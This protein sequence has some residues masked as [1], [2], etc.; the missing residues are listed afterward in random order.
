MLAEFIHFVKSHKLFDRSEPLLV[1]VSGGKDSVCLA[2]LFSLSEYNFTIAHCNFKLRGNESDED[3]LFVKQLAKDLG[4]NY[5]EKV[6]D[7]AQYAEEKKLSIQEAAR[8]LRYNWFREIKEKHGFSKI[9]TAHHQ[10]DSVET[11]FIN[12]FRS[13]GIS[14]LTGIPI[15]SNDIVRPLLF[16]SRSDI[17]RHIQTFNLN[18]RE[19][20]S[21]ITNDYL[22]N[23]IR[24]ELIP[25]IQRL[26]N[27]SYNGLLKS[28]EFLKSDNVLFQYL[29]NKEAK[30]F[31]KNK[32]DKLI[33]DLILL[34]QHP[35]A[36]NILFQLLKPYGFHKN[37]V[38]KILKSEESGKIFYSHNFRAAL[39]RNELIISKINEDD[40][41]T[42][43]LITEHESEIGFPLKLNLEKIAVN[44][45]EFNFEKNISYI[46]ADK[47]IWP[48]ELRK[49]QNGDSFVPLGMK[50]RKKVSDFLIDEKVSM[51]E[52]ENTWVL[53]SNNEIVWLVGH[54][55]SDK[56]KITDSTQN[57]LKLEIIS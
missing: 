45:V 37:E 57:V 3:A 41:V 44:Q 8:N 48:L 39:N 6:F 17:D 21:N 15:I 55:I 16:A 4:V 25:V 56:F 11:F 14:G 18:Y 10:E 22:R 49:W 1:A 7:T 52:K 26:D 38:A 5:F 20:S 34:K 35:M 32:E 47:I 19:D 33:I 2:H 28:I 54:R 40:V 23:K 29:L 12:L 30:E 9:V 42:S 50:G 27:R 53:L 13:S 36:E 51:L 31:I 43:I 24:H 46:D